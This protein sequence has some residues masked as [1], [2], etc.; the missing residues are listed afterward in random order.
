VPA[1]VPQVEPGRG[2]LPSKKLVL[3]GKLPVNYQNHFSVIQSITL[4]FNFGG[5]GLASYPTGHRCGA[6]LIADL[7]L[8]KSQSISWHS[9]QKHP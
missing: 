7:M 6:G 9:R 8:S 5:Q 1:L 3:T 2:A 4:K